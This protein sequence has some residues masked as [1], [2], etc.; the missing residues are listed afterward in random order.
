M[1]LTLGKLLGLTWFYLVRI[2]RGQVFSGLHLAFPELS[3]GQRYQIAKLNYINYGQSFIETLMIPCLSQNFLNSQIEWYGFENYLAAQNK[4][5]GVFLLTL[6]MGSWELMSVAGV[7][8]GVPLY[9]ITKKFKASGINKAWVDLRLNQGLKLIS[10]E[11]STFEILRVL[12]KGAAVGFILDQFMGPPPGVKTV[13]FGK[14]TGTASGLALFAD[15]TGVPVLPVYNFR[16]N[17]G[18]INIVFE[19]ELNFMEQG[20]TRKNIS[21]M[22]QLY[23][24]KIEDIVKKHPE[25]WLWL[26]R[27]WKPF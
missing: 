8:R 6:H 17:E 11:K 26:H 1:Q 19:P 12:K 4:G 14:E 15:R 23:T 7:R 2:R 25:Q 16:T 18:K 24:S 9:N 22:T 5:K 10:E 21:F 20:D 27:R 13:F 3:D